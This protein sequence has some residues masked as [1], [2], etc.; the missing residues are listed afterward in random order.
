MDTDIFLWD[1]DGSLADYDGGLLRGL[2]PL[3][4]PG[5][6]PLTLWN[7]REMD[8]K[9][10]FVRARRKLVQAQPGWWRNLEPLEM[11]FRI[12]H[13]ATELGFNN[14]VLTKGPSQS[15]VAWMEKKEWCTKHLGKDVDV[16]IVSNKS[17]VYGK[18]LYDDFG[19]YV[20]GWLRWRSRGLAIVPV[21][22]DRN[23]FHEVHEHPNVV[24]WDGSE[25]SFEKVRAA[26]VS[27]KNRE[28]GQPW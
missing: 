21:D 20:A 18:V 9:Y 7:L 11:G 12:F 13:L 24:L 17:G 3:A 22:R 8:R 15:A 16:H 23:E 28:S 1:M 2:L 5:E 4:G 25:E 19:P 26:L 10:A 6:E 14:Q 27:V